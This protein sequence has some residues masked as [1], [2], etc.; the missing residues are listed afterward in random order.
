MYFL[1]PCK[2][3]YG[4]DGYGLNEYGLDGYGLDGYGLDGYGLDLI[5]TNL[6]GGLPKRNP[7]I[8]RGSTCLTCLFPH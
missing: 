5:Y 7:W 1:R 8:C 3:G 2:H 6:D 4:L